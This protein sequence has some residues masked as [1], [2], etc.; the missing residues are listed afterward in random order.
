MESR[1]DGSQGYKK[2]G[3]SGLK[4]GPCLAGGEVHRPDSRTRPCL[5]GGEVHRPGFHKQ[6]R[7]EGLMSHNLC[8]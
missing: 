4:R 1:T 8:L 7:L 2:E 3:L 6:L 5:A